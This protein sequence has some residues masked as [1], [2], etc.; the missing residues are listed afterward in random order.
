M[1]VKPLPRMNA[2]MFK[3]LVD[4]KPLCAVTRCR[5][6]SNVEDIFKFY[7]DTK[8]DLDQKYRVLDDKDY[9]RFFSK[10]ALRREPAFTRQITS[11]AYKV[12]KRMIS[13]AEGMPNEAIFPFTRLELSTRAG[14]KMVF[15]E[16]ELAT[17]LQ[18]IPSQGLPPLLLELHAWQQQLHRPPALPAPRDV[19]ATSGAQ[20]GIYQCAELLL[21]TGDAVVTTEYSYSGVFSVLRPY[22]PDIIGIP[23]D[24]DGMIPDTLESALNERLTRGLPMPKMLYLIPTGN[25]P[26]GTVLPEPRR[27]QIYE[28]A[29]KYDLL[30]VEDDPYMFL[31]YTEKVP[32]SFL[33]LDVCGRVI[34]LD[35][36]SK[37]VS[38][39]LRSAWITAPAALI[40]RA[41]LHMQ[42]E[43]LHPC[44]LTQ[45][46]TYH[47]M[48]NR[49]A[50]ASHL[51]STRSFYAHR[52]RALSAALRDVR[53]LVHSNDPAGGL[54]HWARVRD[55]DDV[56]NLVFR[57]AFDRGLM[58]VPGQAFLPDS[59]APCQHLRLTF[60]KI[61]L[62]DMQPAVR[63][64]ADVVR[65]EQK[66]AK[67]QRRR[68]TEL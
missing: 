22:K 61:A 55:V 32:P 51:V 9:A 30:I 2:K 53:D 12:G 23:E 21:N 60:S 19:L 59:R 56:Y 29:C 8:C 13:L 14:G 37:V 15:D 36:L 28:L 11:L 10:R 66:L 42:A 68:A 31:N 57:T 47:L 58:L 65:V 44:T 49:S 39:G 4:A 1:I 16:K 48:R 34:R 45:A 50:F 7:S 17:A 62:A 3:K 6:S 38:S 33:S 26:T 24:E 63:L 5:Y 41:E 18:Y 20:H 46:I 25:N 40:H 54:F 27:R 35:S 64:L 67:Q 52:M 43:V